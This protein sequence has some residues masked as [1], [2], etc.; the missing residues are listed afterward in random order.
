MITLKASD[1]DLLNIQSELDLKVEGIAELQNTKVLEALGGAI[2]TVG[3]KAFK[4]AIDIEAKSKPKAY[5]HI[6]E[7]NKV[8]NP[9]ARLF[10]LYKET[11]FQN[12]LLIKPGFIKSRVAVPV[13][14]ELLLPGRTGK[15]VAAKHVFRDKATIMEDGKAIIYRTSKPTPIPDGG[16]I[17]FVAAG[18]IIKNYYP[19]GKEVRG[20]FEKFFRYWFGN[21]LNAVVNSSGIIQ[22]MDKTTAS[23]LNK[24]GAGSAQVRTAIINLL[25]QYSQGEEVI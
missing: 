25:E 3:A 22:N 17:R 14:P 21:K 4:K 24:K 15:S 1:F 5:H 19:G 10:F 16:F 23:V 7:W 18:T 2:F 12:T 8:G 11:S 6:Y 9:S 20:S 13:A